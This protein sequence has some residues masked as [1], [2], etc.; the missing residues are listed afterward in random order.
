MKNIKTIFNGKERNVKI[1]D[2]IWYYKILD[3]YK[4]EGRNSKDIKVRCTCQCR[5]GKITEKLLLRSLLT[6][7]TKSCGCYN[8]EL[9]IKRNSKHNFSKKRIYKIWLDMRKR[10]N[11]PNVKRSKNY[12]LKGIKVCEEWE[13]FLNFYNWSLKNNYTDNLTIERID[14]EKGYSPENCKWIPKSEQ[15]KNRTTNHYIEYQ[16]KIK[17]LTD[18]SIELNIKRTTLNARIKRG[19]SIKK[20]FET[21]L[22]K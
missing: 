14:N 17:T 19:W 2:T 9:V 12:Y 11:N 3:I 15:S 16:G 4:S 6:G 8:S 22:I 18:W 21:P 7:N 5:C 1:G 20:A 13:N 10:C